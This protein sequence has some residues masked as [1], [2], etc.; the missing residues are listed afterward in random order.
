[1][2][3]ISHLRG[4]KFDLQEEFAEAE[5]DLEDGDNKNALKFG[6]VILFV[7]LMCA[8]VM[9]ITKLVSVSYADTAARIGH[10]HSGG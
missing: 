9:Q 8:V 3:K 2:K 1:M 7:A 10:V 6:A 5:R 4:L